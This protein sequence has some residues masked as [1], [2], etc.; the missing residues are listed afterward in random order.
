MYYCEINGA[1]HHHVVAYRTSA[2]LV[3]WGAQAIAFTDPSLDNNGAS[4]TESPFVV[5]HGGSWYLFIGPRGGY[6]GTDVFHSND[7]LPFAL[8]DYAGHVPLHAAEVVDDGGTWWATG[9]GS[10]E[11]G[12]Y[13]APL[14]R[15]S[16]RLNSSHTDISRMPSS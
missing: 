8:A 16:T 2:D 6:V 7:P 3:H 4:T 15:K 5:Q 1:D 13:L 12:L 14:D 10:F 9:A 11:H